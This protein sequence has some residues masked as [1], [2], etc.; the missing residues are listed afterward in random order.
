MKQSLPSTFEMPSCPVM[1][2]SGSLNCLCCS[3]LGSDIIGES[4]LFTSPARL[5]CCTNIRSMKM[6]PCLR[7]G[8][9]CHGRVPVK[10]WAA[11]CTPHCAVLAYPSRQ[12][13]SCISE[14]DVSIATH[15][16][17]DRAIWEL[18]ILSLQLRNISSLQAYSPI[19]VRKSIM[20]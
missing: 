15:C 3:W 14:R 1:L 8:T 2:V 10:K 6:K 20:P 9:C 5:L 13:R 7:S 12:L 4:A 19:P 16:L 18:G 17:L 11:Q